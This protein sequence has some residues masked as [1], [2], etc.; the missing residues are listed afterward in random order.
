MGQIIFFVIAGLGLVAVNWSTVKGFLPSFGGKT[1]G[2]RAGAIAA[3]D[4]V[5]E[6]FEKEGCPEGAAAARLCGPHFWHPHE[7]DVTA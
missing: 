4:S 7:S 2:G 1:A 3:L 5:I 6:Y